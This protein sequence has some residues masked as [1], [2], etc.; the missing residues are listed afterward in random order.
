[1]RIAIAEVGLDPSIGYLHVCRPERQALV[2]DLI[3]P[4]RP[5]VDREVRAFIRSQ[6]FTPR[7]FVIDAKGGLQSAS[8]TGTGAGQRSRRLDSPGND[9]GQRPRPVLRKS[10]TVDPTR[11]TGRR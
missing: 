11:L 2:Y 6:A 7:D 9:P 8:R 1:V 4:Y 10:A 3:E 5:Q